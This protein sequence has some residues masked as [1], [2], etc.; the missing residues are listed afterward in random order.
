MMCGHNIV[1]GRRKDSESAVKEIDGD[2]GEDEEHCQLAGGAHLC[3]VS[4]KIR[5]Q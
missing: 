1:D 4:L 2:D 5:K 3:M